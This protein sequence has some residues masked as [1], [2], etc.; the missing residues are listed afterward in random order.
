MK[1]RVRF[2]SDVPATEK[3]V[4]FLRDLLTRRKAA[5]QEY[6]A[7]RDGKLHVAVGEFWAAASIPDD[8]T[9]WEARSLISLL[10]DIGVPF[11]V[12]TQAR[13]AI[14]IRRENTS[15]SAFNSC[16]ALWAF[17]DRKSVV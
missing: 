7:L 8:L 6:A 1:T 13:R 15:I 3:Q 12:S 10:K 9:K 2:N 14:H 11:I 5:A 16:M 4:A 17:A